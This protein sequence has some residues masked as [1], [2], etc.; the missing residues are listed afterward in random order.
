MRHHPRRDH[1]AIHRPECDGGVGGAEL[2][3]NSAF[4]VRLQDPMN[5]PPSEHPPVPVEEPPETIENPTKNPPPGEDD[6]E[7]P[8]RDPRI[9]G[10]PARK[11][12][13]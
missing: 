10:Q 5:D 8:V 9:P 12:V 7:P 6:D 2:V 1:L 11:K 3:M 13:N 4:A